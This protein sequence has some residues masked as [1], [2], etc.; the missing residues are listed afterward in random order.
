MIRF[1]PVFA[2]LFLLA[3][4]GA[5]SSSGGGGGPAGPP[6]GFAAG[7]KAQDIGALS[8][9]GALSYEA[10]VFSLSSS[11][12]DIWNGADAFRFAY[13][14]LSGDGEI[15]ARVLSLDPTNEWAKSGVMI[16]ESLAPGSPFAMSVVTPSHGTSLQWRALKDQGCD[17]AFG[18]PSPPPPGCAS[19]AKATC[20]AR[21]RRAT[22]ATGPSSPAGRSR[23]AST[24]SSASA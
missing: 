21:S 6:A 3:C 24:S 2:P 10:G 4:D 14:P 16:R 11:G 23:W 17:L 22:A 13:L 9:P 15:T 18:P 20:S 5:S 1:A 19:A 12:A 7:W 8:R